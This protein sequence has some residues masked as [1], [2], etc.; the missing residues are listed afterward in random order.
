VGGHTVSQN[1]NSFTPADIGTMNQVGEEIDK[2]M[3]P[4]DHQGG[5]YEKLERKITP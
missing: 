5:L 1:E 3:K 2:E 4:N